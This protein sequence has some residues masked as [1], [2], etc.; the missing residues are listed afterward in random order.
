[1]NLSNFPKRLS[2]LIK[3]K[4]ITI[5]QFSTEIGCSEPTISRYVQGKSLP[6]LNIAVQMANYFKCSIDY[7]LGIKDNEFDN[8]KSKDC[9]PFGERLL[10]LCTEKNISRYELQNLTNIPESVMRYWVRGKTKPSLIN[11]VKIAR[12]LELSVDYVLGREV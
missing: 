7:L 6:T 9:P 3:D 4:D 2:E 1:M 12:K 5:T 10:E 8:Y 11:I